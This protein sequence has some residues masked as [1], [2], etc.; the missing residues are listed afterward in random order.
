MTS[1]PV[2]V[3]YRSG[4]R[5]EC[6]ARPSALI[7]SFRLGDEGLCDITV[8]TGTNSGD[9]N[10]YPDKFFPNQASP[11]SIWISPLPTGREPS[12]IVRGQ[13]NTFFFLRSSSATPCGWDT[14]QARY[15]W[16]KLPSCLSLFALVPKM[17]PVSYC[18]QRST[19]LHLFAPQ[20]SFSN[21]SFYRSA[22]LCCN[23]VRH[24]N[25]NIFGLKK[26]IG[27][28]WD[29]CFRRTFRIFFL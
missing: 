25:W 22:L 1:H 2:S 16:E 27:C 3:H 14:Q 6:I 11:P 8:V 17:T 23:R 5:R 15:I 19:Q 9:V 10:Q 21:C 13:S 12:K 7:L 4:S 24:L 29:I 28:R 18:H 26:R 20:S